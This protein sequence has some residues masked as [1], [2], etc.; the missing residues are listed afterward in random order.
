MAAVVWP[1]SMD[2]PLQV[3]S[4]YL[5]AVDATNAY[6]WLRPTRAIQ[7]LSLATGMATTLLEEE[8]STSW[9][10]VDGFIYF[11]GDYD[12][13]K[14]VA[15]TGGMPERLHQGHNILWAPGVDGTQLYYGGSNILVKIDGMNEQYLMQ[16]SMGFIERIVPQGDLLLWEGWQGAV[17]FV[18]KDGSRCGTVIDSLFGFAGWD[19]D[20]TS[21]YLAT[22]DA[23]Y[24]VPY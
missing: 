19:H 12:L 20:E 14:R 21:F 6:V 3:G 18:S 13:M 15:V 4:D 1:A 16:G 10:L 22:E 2:T 7:A 11:A 8:K 23:I 5:F 17:G 24:Q 9:I